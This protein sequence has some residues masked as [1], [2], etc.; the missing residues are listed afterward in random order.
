MRSSDDRIHD[1]REDLGEPMCLARYSEL[2]QRSGVGPVED[3]VKSKC[4]SRL[5]TRLTNWLM[6]IALNGPVFK[7]VDWL[8]ILDIWKANGQRGR[9]KGVW[10]VDNT[11]IADELQA[12]YDAAVDRSR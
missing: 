5:N 7:D 8:A 6:L 10:K 2:L 12:L 1:S 11:E 3:R 9:Y 4:R